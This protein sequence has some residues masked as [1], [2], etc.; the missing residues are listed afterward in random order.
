MTLNS[1]FLYIGAYELCAVGVTECY[2]EVGYLVRGMQDF[3]HD[4]LNDHQDRVR[5]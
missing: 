1:N 4:I 5:M 2:S 3:T